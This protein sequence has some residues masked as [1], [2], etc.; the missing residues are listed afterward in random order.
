MKLDTIWGHFMDK[1]IK[2]SIKEK[3]AVVRAILADR[4]SIKGSAGQI[5]CASNTIRR[6]L[7]QYQLYGIKGLKFR[8]GSYDGAF[9][10]RV[11][12]WCLKK[13]YL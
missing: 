7:I 2:Y 13:G 11:V 8:K 1:R 6:W 3:E 9:K 5:C 10:V 4:S 12:R